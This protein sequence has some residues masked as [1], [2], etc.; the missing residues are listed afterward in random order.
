MLEFLV[1]GV[2]HTEESDLRTE[3]L[4]IAGDF[5]QRLGAGSE[6]QRVELAFV[7]QRQRGK[8]VWQG[9]DHVNVARGQEFFFARFQ[10]TVARVSLTPRAMPI[11]AR[12]ERDGLISASGTRIDMSTERGGSAAQNGV[13]HL[14]MEP[15]EPLLAALEEAFSRGAEDIGHLEGRPWH[16]LRTAAGIAI[17]RQGQGVERTGGGVQVLLR[18]VRIDGSLFQIAMTQQNLDGP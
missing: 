8:L 14:E 11:A 17:F 18:Q 10:P 5:E 6:Q 7:L 13:P 15:G 2:K 1:P 16:L 12:V 4:G 3:A 9:K